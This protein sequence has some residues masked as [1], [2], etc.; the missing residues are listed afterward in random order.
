MENNYETLYKKLIRLE[1]EDDAIIAKEPSSDDWENIKDCVVWQQMPIEHFFWLLKNKS[2]FL[3]RI[4][5]N[6]PTIERNP[7]TIFEHLFKDDLGNAANIKKAFELIADIT[8]ISCWYMEEYLNRSMY[9]EFSGDKGIALQTTVEK[10]VQ[11]LHSTSENNG[12]EYR[13]GS[14]LYVTDK[15]VKKLAISIRGGRYELPVDN[16]FFTKITSEANEKEF[17]LLV[18]DPIMLGKRIFAKP[19]RELYSIP[20]DITATFD[21]LTL[22][23]DIAG[24]KNFM[25]LLEY[26]LN[27]SG[28][29]MEAKED[30]GDNF[31]HYKLHR[32]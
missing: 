23:K 14:L 9:R 18:Q 15:L 12:W 25:D 24:S 1:W 27:M 5:E 28:Y 17:R 20:V 11:C 2:L 22:F 30:L 10:L 26:L 16:S 21:S 13:F 4:T 6:S 3:K 19:K 29:R 31:M 32:K 8:Y 7:Y